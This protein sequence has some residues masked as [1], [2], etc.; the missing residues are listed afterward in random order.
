MIDDDIGGFYGGWQNDIVKPLIDF[1]SVRISS[2]R[3]LTP[4]GDIGPMMGIDNDLGKEICEVPKMF[5]ING[6]KF[7]AIISAAIAFRKKDI[8]DSGINFDSRFIGSGFEDTLFCYYMS[9][10]FEQCRFVCYNKCKL[11]HYHEMKSQNKHFEFNQKLFLN[12]VANDI[13]LRRAA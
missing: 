12:I 10:Y 2:A 1:S 13:K 8:V 3:L 5:N 4:D 7:G 9:R 6:Y 11:I